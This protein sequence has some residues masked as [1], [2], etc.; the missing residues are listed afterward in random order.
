MAIQ[1]GSG[2]VVDERT[3]LSRGA[4]EDVI[5]TDVRRRGETITRIVN[6][7]NQENT[8]SGERPAPKLDWQRVIPQGGTVVTG[9]FNA[10]RKRWDPRCKVQWD[11]AFWEDLIDKNGLDIGNDGWPTHHWSRED[12]D[13]ESVIDLTLANQ[14]IVKWHILAEDHATGSDPEVIE[15]EVGEARQEEADHNRVVGWNFAAMPE[16]DVE[17]AEKLWME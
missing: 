7:H 17:G 6:V 16:K 3:A 9:D 5:P 4:N 11:A 15:W 13:G 12:Q 8:H 1:S 2:L 14:P 10:H